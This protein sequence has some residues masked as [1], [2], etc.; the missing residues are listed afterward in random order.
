MYSSATTTNGKPQTPKTPREGAS[1]YIA[2]GFR[3]IPV[4]LRSKNPAL[5]E[6]QHLRVGP[7]NLDDYFPLGKE[8][9]VGLLLG[10]PSNGLIDVDLDCDEALR[11][12]P[13]LLPPT[14]WITGRQ[15]KPRSHR[16][17]VVNDSPARA[18]EQF[19]DLDKAILVE[20]RSTRA[21]SIAP[22]SVHETGEPIG[23]YSFDESGPA[24][25][26]IAELRAAVGA[27]AV[28]ALLARHWPG[29]G[30]RQDAAMFLAGGLLRAGWG[31]DQVEAF[32][33]SVA[34]AARD[35]EPD[36]RVS[37]IGPTARAIREGTNVTGWPSLAGLVGDPTVR[38]AIEWLRLAR[39]HSPTTAKAKAPIRPLAPYKPFPVH[40]LPEPIASYVRQAA[41]ALNCDSAYIALPCLA[42]AASLIGNSRS[43]RLK[44]DWYEPA[45]VWA[46]VVADSGTLKS[47]AHNLATGFLFKLQKE[48]IQ[49]YRD[50]LVLYQQEKEQYDARKREAKKRAGDGE[51]A[52]VDSSPERP[53]CHRI[54]S[55]DPT[56]ESLADLL[57]KN[58]RGILLARDELRGWLGSFTRYKGRSNGTDLPGWLEMFRAEALI[59]DRKTTDR[60]TIFVPHAAVSVTGTIQPGILAQALTAEHL[61]AGLAARLLLAMPPKLPK[62][63]S[64]DEVHPEV[65]GAYEDV[66]RKLLELDMDKGS[67]GDKVPFAVRLT[68]EAKKAWVQFYDAWAKEQ[69]DVEGELAACYSKLE[70][71]AAR[72]TLLHHVVSRVKQSTDCDP[73]EPASVAAGVEL[74]RWF[75]HEARR[76]YATLRESEGD[77]QARRL[78]EFIRSHGGKMTV[79]RLRLSNTSRYPTPEAA[80][81]ALHALAE[82][83]LAD[84]VESPAGPRGGRPTRTLV[85]RLDT[86]YFKTYETPDDGD[87]EDDGETGVG[88]TKPPTKPLAPCGDP[89]ENE[90]FVGFEACSTNTGGQEPVP[91]QERGGGSGGEVSLGS[92]G[93]VSL[94][95]SGK[96]ADLRTQQE[97]ESGTLATCFKTYET[98]SAERAAFHLIRDAA[99]LQTVLPAL[100]ESTLIGL[101]TE[102]TGLDPRAS[103]VRLLSL[104][105]DR[106]VF[107]IDLFAVPA[108]ELAP[109]FGLLAEKEVVGHKL[110]FDLQFLT[111]LGFT[112]GIAHDTML[113]SQLLH[114]PRQAKGFHGLARVAQREIGV[115]LDKDLQ[116]SDWSGPLS[117]EQLAYAAADA[118]VLPPLLGALTAK[119][120]L[121]ALDRAAEIERRCLPAVA[122]LSSSGV[123][124]DKDAW[125]ALAV[126]AVQRAESLARQLDAAVP[127]R[128]AGARPK[129][130]RGQGGN[131]SWNWRSPRQVQ[132]V[133]AL[134]NVRLKRTDDDA[135]AGVDHPAAALLRE[136]RSASKLA[137]TY[138]PDW[139]KDS[140]HGGRLYTDWRQIGCITG[141]MAGR[142]PNLQNLPGD[143]RYRACFRAPEGRVLIKCDYSQIELRI[144]AKITGDRAMLD[145]YGRAEDLHTLTARRML[146]KAEVSA[147]ERKLAKPVNFGLIYGLS[148]GSL[149]RKA[150]A[151]YGL[152]L[153]PQDAERYRRAFFHNYPGIASWHRRLRTEQASAVRTLAG[154]LCPLPEKHFYG[155]RANYVV[156][157]TGGDGLK[158]ALALLWERREQCQGA[159]PVLAVHDEIVVEADAGQAEAAATWLK[160]AMLDGMAPLIDPVPVEVEIKV[161]TTWGGDS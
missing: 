25:V 33:R 86:T 108:A 24:R 141:R 28:A 11:A 19:K 120:K 159:F 3:P 83:D 56:I 95:E 79:R 149:R 18:A 92:G 119:A 104:A 128:P 158:T 157:G 84:W 53:T 75:A 30:S 132:E 147:A 107:L 160:R 68:P 54:V 96:E 50:D 41:A 64:E 103:R 22:P 35:D 27:V 148:A 144:A 151:E 117:P 14:P 93:G 101:D 98:P 36:Q 133:F 12:G 57:E 94:D 134:L 156:Q 109:V 115:S 142:S 136:Y 62:R 89:Q 70:A 154:R 17:Y 112:P 58:P 55:S 135:L 105:T 47:P 124:F 130:M 23:W 8:Q 48:L 44:R 122:W 49:K 65:R 42:A 51:T 31:E 13:L 15:S 85:L 52:D 76:I 61:E 123:S 16:W 6:W 114:G 26:G 161:G 46:G 43:I 59:I 63:W 45:V 87:D 125:L 100:D 97:G 150:K 74:A 32:V 90:G 69:A 5:K 110:L 140:F 121:A 139:F 116:T 127:Q 91:E 138:G 21:Q 137:T 82:A 143:P 126:E 80:E 4:P 1:F 111:P 2:C 78:I 34:V 155:T 81:E 153:A 146:G 20:L 39:W 102:T 118:A 72:L 106:G 67:E 88:A 152:D 7:E 77:R 10:E 145:A 129:G 37:V 71:Y 73:I 40:C 99:C 29:K 113:L 131:S 66:L 38:K 9:N 60:P